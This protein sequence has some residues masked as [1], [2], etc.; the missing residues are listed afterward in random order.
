M[1]GDALYDLDAE[2]LVQFAE[3][4]HGAVQIDRFAITGGAQGHHQS[5]TLAE[6]IDADQVTTLGE[7][8]QRAQQF[9][10]LVLER[11]M[12]ENRQ[13]E[14]RLGDKNVAGDRLERGTCRIWPP[15]IVTGKDDA[16]PLI[17]QPRL[18]RTQDMAGR[19]QADLDAIEE[20]VFAIPQRPLNQGMVITIARPHDGQRRLR[21]IDVA[22]A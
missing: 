6:R 21:G 15:F 12:D 18:G 19:M 22:V 1:D 10:D 13:G 4:D 14:G 9:G 20:Q 5:L 2:A 7:L 8:R 3:L 17:F 11:R 16:R